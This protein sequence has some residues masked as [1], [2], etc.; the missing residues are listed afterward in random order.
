MRYTTSPKRAFA[1]LRRWYSVILD[2]YVAYARA[3]RHSQ[4]NMP[5]I[6]I[7]IKIENGKHMLWMDRMLCFS[8]IE[9]WVNNRFLLTNS[10]VRCLHSPPEKSLKAA[11][12]T[13]L[14]LFKKETNQPLKVLLNFTHRKGDP[15][16][17]YRFQIAK[18]TQRNEMERYAERKLIRTIYGAVV[19]RY[20]DH[21]RSSEGP[22]KPV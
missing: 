11:F 1:L 6:R 10:K 22:A 7:I 16:K 3:T 17:S 13:S 19:Y 15:R 14:H 5:H 4:K 2:S 8:Y 12:G 9:L 21:P 20:G 18:N